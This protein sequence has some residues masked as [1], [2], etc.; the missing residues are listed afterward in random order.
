MNGFCSSE[1]KTRSYEEGRGAELDLDLDNSYSPERLLVKDT[2]RAPSS[3][4]IMF[5]EPSSPSLPTSS[6]ALPH[7]LRPPSFPTL[8]HRGPP[9]GTA[10]GGT[11]A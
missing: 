9:P 10:S 8:P 7:S 4:S 6:P 11:L 2:P 3:E 1:T 5:L